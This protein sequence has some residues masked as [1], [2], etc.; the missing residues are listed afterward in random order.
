MCLFVDNFCYNYGLKK[1]KRN[2]MNIDLTPEVL[3]KQL[4]MGDSLK[5]LSRCKELSTTQQVLKNLLR[6]S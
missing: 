6:T 5:R 3:V 1:K 2:E 4:G